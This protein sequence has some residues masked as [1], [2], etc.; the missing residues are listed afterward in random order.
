MDEIDYAEPFSEDEIEAG[1]HRRRVGGKWDRLGQLQ[2]DFLVSQG[3]QPSHRLL[4]V[5]CGALRGGIRFVEYLDPRNYFGIDINESLIEAGLDREL[6]EELR[7][8]L[9][10]TNLRATD[11]F[12][13]DFGV[14]FDFALAQSLFTHVSLNHVRL[15]LYRV[16][17]TMR[18][19]GRFYVTF[20]EADPDF[21]IDGI[22]ESKRGRYTERNPYWYYRR[23]MEWAASFSP[24]RMRYI[25]DWGH[26]VGQK[27]IELTRV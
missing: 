21:P 4:D 3:L 8:K 17:R 16:S 15:C 1:A 19:Q 13:C 25:G 9:P 5:A 6:P 11:R 27:M 23:D 20:F 10:R 26:P 24:W 22:V 2:L 12:E 14:Q 7:P 18:T